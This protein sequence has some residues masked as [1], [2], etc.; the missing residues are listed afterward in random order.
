MSDGYTLFPEL[1]LV[2]ES[3]LPAHLKP[4]FD[5]MVQRGELGLDLDGNEIRTAEEFMAD[6]ARRH[7]R[8]LGLE[9]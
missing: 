6:A 9:T 7:L 4:L 2:V 1:G 8:D 3:T 5:E